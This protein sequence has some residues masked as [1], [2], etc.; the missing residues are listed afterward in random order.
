VATLTDISSDD[1]LPILMILKGP[2][3]AKTGNHVIRPF[4]AEGTPYFSPLG[5]QVLQVP[6]HMGVLEVL[7]NSSK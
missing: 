1:R 4:R 2:A 5:F 6:E 3:K 7:E